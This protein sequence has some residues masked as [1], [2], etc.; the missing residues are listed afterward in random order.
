[1]AFLFEVPTV[2][3]AAVAAGQVIRY[4]SILKDV[5]TGR[6]VAHVQETGLLSTLASNA[7]GMLNMF[8][9]FSAVVS[10][11]NAG[12][13]LVA[14]WQL[15]RMDRKIE[16]LKDMFTGFQNFQIANLALAGLGIGVSVAGFA[17]V[18]YKL[19]KMTL[20]LDGIE[21]TIREGFGQ[22]RADRLRDFES[23][24]N[25]LLDE[26]EEGWKAA[27][28]GTANWTHV[29]KGLSHLVHVY[30]GEIEKHLDARN[31]DFPTLAYLI[32]RY[33]VCAVTRLECLVLNN[34]LSN[35][36]DFSRKVADRSA[37]LLDRLTPLDMAEIVVQTAKPASPRDQAILAELP[38][39]QA[40]VSTVRE[41]QDLF[42][43]KPV[44]IET[45]IDKRADGRDYVARLKDDRKDPLLLLR[46]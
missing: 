25:G 46:P 31:Y 16:A 7:P 15:N 9:P 23:D 27:D 38:R 36:L 11:V 6:I 20:K 32:E 41:L 8:N 4:G 33:R 30:P 22:Q 35:A 19:D 34:E 12:S 45:L 44:L 39:A 40:F 42:T 24:V 14:N 29:A 3:Q 17:L 5:G 10:A 21:T 26:A 1:M 18:K 13:G 43:T 37:N 2:W 28:G